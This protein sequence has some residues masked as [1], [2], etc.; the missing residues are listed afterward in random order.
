MAAFN[1]LLSG[2]MFPLG[3]SN[4]A[5]GVLL[6]IGGELESGKGGRWDPSLGRSF[7]RLLGRSGK[8]WHPYIFR[9][10]IA[11]FCLRRTTES[12][13]LENTSS[14]RLLLDRSHLQFC[15]KKMNS[16]SQRCFE[17]VSQ[18]AG[19]RQ[20]IDVKNHLS[21]DK[22]RFYAWTTVYEEVIKELDNRTNGDSSETM[23]VYEDCIK[24]YFKKRAASG[25]VKRLVSLLK[26]I[27]NKRERFIIVSIGFFFWYSYI[28]YICLTF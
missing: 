7:Q 23:K 28:M 20:R 6:H 22:Q 14:V 18:R 21:A 8:E 1:V 4:D 5:P 24:K 9:A 16:R 27:K 2:T 13:W 3:L 26:M 25:R 19:A 15:Q 11:P 12:T 17:K 10:L